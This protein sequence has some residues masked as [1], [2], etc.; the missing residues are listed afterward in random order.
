MMTQTT[1]LQNPTR[2]GMLSMK[3]EPLVGNCTNHVNPDLWHPEMPNGRPSKRVLDNLVE[4]I[5]IAKEYCNTCPSKERCLEIGSQPKDLPYGIWGGKLA[6]E[7]ILALGHVRS[8]FAQQSE[9]GRA[10][11]FHEYITQYMEE[12]NG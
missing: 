4:D 11:D 2:L 5:L 9:L 3:T 1:I 7:R 10:M 6:G 8:D 12:M